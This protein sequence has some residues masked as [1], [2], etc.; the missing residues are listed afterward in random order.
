MPLSEHEQ[1]LLDEMERNLYQ[2]EA[3]VVSSPTAGSLRPNY[4]GIV[5]GAVVVVAGLAAL[6]VGVIMKQPVVGVAGFVV[7][8][9]GV[10][11][12]LRPARPDAAQRAASPRPAGQKQQSSGGGFAETM[13]RRW[14]KR[15]DG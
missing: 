10:F 7:M 15:R 6:L 1:R 4:R 11:L 5:L 8:G 13:Q 3:D 9:A 12:A 2:S 14:D